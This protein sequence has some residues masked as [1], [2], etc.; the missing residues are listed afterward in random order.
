MQVAARVRENFQI[1][2]AGRGY[3]RKYLSVFS[4]YIQDSALRKPTEAVQIDI[5]K[6]AFLMRKS[7]YH[8]NTI[9]MLNILTNGQLHFTSLI[10]L[11]DF[12]SIIIVMIH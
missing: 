10:I 7:S 8:G 12:N 1:S 2:R 4:I 11:S 3:A 5:R 6:T 9:C